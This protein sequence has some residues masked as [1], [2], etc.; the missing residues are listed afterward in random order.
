MLVAVRG[1]A[2]RWSEELAELLAD[3]DLLNAVF[4]FNQHFLL[5]GLPFP[6]PP[7]HLPN[8]LLIKLPLINLLAL[9]VLLH[10]LVMGHILLQGL[11]DFLLQKQLELVLIDGVV[12]QGRGH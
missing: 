4:N 2:A 12:R 10:A 11:L 8:E 6:R 3:L 5:S 9:L 1:E 7:P